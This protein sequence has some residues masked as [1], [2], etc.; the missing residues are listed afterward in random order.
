MSLKNPIVSVIMPSLNV[1]NYIEE[2]LNSVINQTLHDLE[3]I[4]IDAGSTDG[5]LEILEKFVK[6][7]SRIKLLKSDKK[8]YGYQV[9][10]GLNEANG[11]YI[12]IVET[13]DYIDINMFESLYNLSEDSQIDI[14]KGNFYHFNDADSNN[15]IFKKDIFKSN[16]SRNESFTL[17]DEVKFLE[18]HPSIWAGIYKKSFL[19]KFNIKFMEEPGGGWVDNP[20]FYETAICARSIIYTD[21]AFYFYRESNPNSSSNSL[22]D[23]NIPMKRVLEMFDILEKYG[24]KNNDIL[25]SFY[26]RLFR[27]IEIIL[28]NN[29]NSD[30]DLSYDVCENIHNVVMKV[31]EDIVKTHM[32]FN[33]QKLYFKYASPLFMSRFEG[34]LNTS[35]EDYNKL[36]EENEFLH[37][38]LTYFRTQYNETNYQKSQ[39]EKKLNSKE[40]LIKYKN[41][42]EPKFINLVPEDFTTDGLKLNEK[43]NFSH[44]YKISVIMPVFNG[45]KFLKRSVN[46]ILEQ[47][48][49]SI[50]IV[51]INDGSTDNSLEI[52][53]DYQNNYDFVT[54]L[55]QKNSGSGKARNFGIQEAKGEY[56]AFLDADDFFMDND[57]LEKM[58][59]VAFSNNAN[60][61]TANIK[62]DVDK[63]GDFKPF[64]PF[65]YYTVDD[66]ILP[67]AY[68]IPWSF[69]KNIFK[70]DFLISNEIFFPDLLRGQDPVFLAEILVKVDKIFAVATDLYAYVYNSDVAKASNYRKLYDQLLHYKM[71]FDY[72]EDNR[73]SRRQNEYFHKIFLFIGR[74]DLENS[75]MAL[76][77]IQEIFKDH[78]NFLKRLQNH[79]YLKYMGL[80]EFKEHLNGNPII[81]VII[82]FSDDDS[83]ILKSVNSILNQSIED[84]EI[85]LINMDSSD[86][87]LYLMENLS[88]K[89]SR[90]K[91]LYSN[92]KDI[93]YANNLGLSES[94]GDYIY[95]FKPNAILK[96]NALKIFLENMTMNGSE[97]VLCNRPMSLNSEE[98]NFDKIFTNVNYNYHSFN[99][100]A[101]S[102]LIFNS[103]FDNL[104]KF[105][106]KEFITLD[107]KFLENVVEC[108]SSFHIKTILNSVKLSYIPKFLFE[109]INPRKY[110]ALN[111]YLN[112]VDSKVFTVFDI[113][114]NVEE[115]LKENNLYET[116]KTNFDIYKIN[117][118]TSY[119]DVVRFIGSHTYNNHKERDLYKNNSKVLDYANYYG[120]KSEYLG[121]DYSF[122]EKYFTKTKEEF[123]KL[124][125]RDMKFVYLDKHRYSIWE[126]LYKYQ[127]VLKSNSYKEYMK[128]SNFATVE[129]LKSKHN[130]LLEEKDEIISKNNIGDFR[131]LKTKKQ[132]LEDENNNLRKEYWK[133]RNLYDEILNSDAWKST[134]SL[135][136]FKKP[137]K[138]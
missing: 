8:S 127:S 122:A 34:K 106:K 46:S 53:K 38:Q 68:G 61:V 131:E 87:S 19:D 50:E 117:L 28:E 54:V 118:I 59:D 20:F 111:L 137:F 130:L 126:N 3:I 48:L 43:E 93:G 7:D 133:Y 136:K 74:L 98:I 123:N 96:E 103:S 44:E 11:E 102:K 110:G 92:Y 36:V 116:F 35:N 86:D 78:P 55:N 24:C 119:L 67:E 113:C 115:F 27:Y 6:K 37:S 13:D 105:Y 88:S 71:V 15:P 108:E 109:Y 66:V 18:G 112:Q 60:M 76:E 138:K 25:V 23:Y 90:I 10:L 104:Y 80:N 14:I 45:E 121:L 64:G 97:M 29:G 22:N 114:D 4:C 77:C 40:N 125:Y 129:K 95:F 56:I 75:K 12:S 73:F 2:C 120:S 16:I 33:F 79:L 83:T 132:L 51:F 62:H 42:V 30:K 85:I 17:E 26:N 82:P 99:Y 49:D 63:E 124:N 21:D 134:E 5:T 32:K 52:L 9:N 128:I 89:D 69:Y 39:L 72:F 31:D 81:S 84:I 100:D 47:T 91:I 58:Y 57:A 65:H 107:L 1:G 94:R 101:I 41:V 135:R 70:R